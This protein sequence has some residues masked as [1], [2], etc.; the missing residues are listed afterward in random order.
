M[1][2]GTEHTPPVSSFKIISV[3]AT[4]FEQEDAAAS[5]SVFGVEAMPANI[6]AT[7]AA[8]RL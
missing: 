1:V 5:T 7:S 2:G 8:A 6:T 4:P 3:H